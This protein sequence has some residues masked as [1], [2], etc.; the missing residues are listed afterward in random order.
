MTPQNMD[1]H[2]EMMSTGNI[3]FY[4]IQISLKEN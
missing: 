4:S 3:Y 2:K 1:P